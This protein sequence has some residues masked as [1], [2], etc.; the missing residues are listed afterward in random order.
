[1]SMV[2]RR[3]VAHTAQRVR[4]S[5]ATMAMAGTS[6]GSRQHAR[7]GRYECTWLY[8]TEAIVNAILGVRH[9]SNFGDEDDPVIDGTAGLAAVDPGAVGAGAGVAGLTLEVAEP[10]VDG[11]PDHVVD[12][13]D[14]R[15]PVG[16]AFFVACLAGLAGVLAEGG[17]ED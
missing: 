16:I 9:A 17:V 3:S 8:H 10:R 5:P 6:H 14:Q 4:P 2:R 1:M 15:R 7:T 11:L 13:S 12:L